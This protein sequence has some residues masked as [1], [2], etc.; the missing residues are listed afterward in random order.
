MSIMIRHVARWFSR[1]TPWAPR[2]AATT[3]ALAA[4][5]ALTT[6]AAP[7]SATPRSSYVVVLAPTADCAATRNTVTTTY[8]I[9]TST[10]YDAIFCGFAA[11][12]SAEQVAGLR[13]DAAVETVTPDT[14][15]GIG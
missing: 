3:A 9:R 13:S 10:T 4:L 12:L 14:R 7:A 5:A 8:A 6:A 2:L 15:V 1:P 11:R